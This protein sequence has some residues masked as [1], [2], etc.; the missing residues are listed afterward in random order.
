ML[1]GAREQWMA[2][3]KGHSRV[4]KSSPYY[5]FNFSFSFSTDSCVRQRN[6]KS[7]GCCKKLRV[8]RLAV[9]LL[10]RDFQRAPS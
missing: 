9:V 4:K 8:G 1:N 7:K 10:K 2:D 6:L 3:L 5:K